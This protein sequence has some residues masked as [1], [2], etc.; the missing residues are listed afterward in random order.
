MKYQQ[1]LCTY[2][3]IK[4]GCVDRVK[5]W[6]HSLE[7]ERRGGLLQSF[8]DEGVVLEAAF[9]KE[10]KDASYLVYFLRAEDVNQALTIFQKSTLAIDA[11]HKRC[12]DELTEQH[13]ILT[14]VFHVE[15][16]TNATT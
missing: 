3:K 8:L 13:A 7:T 10:E 15:H 2:S 4:E 16:G 6:L 12:W 1:V 11:F 5:S 9:I 14:P